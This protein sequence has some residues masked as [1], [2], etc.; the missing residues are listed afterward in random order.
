MARNMVLSLSHGDTRSTPAPG[1]QVPVQ[2]RP[3]RHVSAD[4]PVAAHRR[5]GDPAQAAEQDFLSDLGCGPRGGAGRGG[6]R[7]CPPPRLVPSLLNP[8]S[9][10][11]YA[12]ACPPLAS[13]L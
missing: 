13:A 6:A 4:V 12:L 8:K 9:A 1:R 7:S 2:G 5:Q 3:A 10:L 11:A